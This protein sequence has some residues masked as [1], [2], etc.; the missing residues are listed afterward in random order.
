MTLRGA[1]GAAMEDQ[2]AETLAEFRL[3][4]RLRA[5]AVHALTASG[6]V[7]GFLALVAII[8]GDLRAGFL[9]L[10]L[11]LFVDGVDGT[12]ARRARVREVTPQVDGAALDC[13]IDY[14][15]Y[16]VVPALMIYWYGFVPDAWAL[17]A[18]A[19]V[20]AVSCYTFANT[21]MKSHDWYFV[22]FPA[23]WNLVVLTFHLTGS[24]PRLNL[25]VIGACAVLTFVP[26]KVVHPFRVRDF[27]WITVPATVVWGAAGLRLVLIEAAPGVHLSEIAPVAFWLWAATSAWLVAVSAW[28]SLF[29]R[30][31]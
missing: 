8:E 28:R 23:I 4:D 1:T 18:A 15:T 10:G 11:A 26:L 29:K 2:M 21:G 7:L 24:D 25:A 17:P 6:A 19:V 31:F 16:V 5:W 14:L 20:M 22:G 27:R 30:R 3:R 13:V 12:L 9:W